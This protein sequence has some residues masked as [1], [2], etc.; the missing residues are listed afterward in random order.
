MGKNFGV[1]CGKMS[2]IFV[3][4]VDVKNK[5]LEAWNLLTEKNQ[6]GCDLIASSPS[7]GK[8]FY[9][10]YESRLANI[11]N[12]AGVVY[13]EDCGL[14]VEGGKVGIDVRSNG[15]YIICPPSANGKYS[16]DV[17][18][19]LNPLP[20]WIFLLLS[21]KRSMKSDRAENENQNPEKR[22]KVTRCLADQFGN[23]RAAMAPV[24]YHQCAKL[25]ER[26]STEKITGYDP[27]EIWGLR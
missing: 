25:C 18:E 3:V 7:G 24:L 15:G 12:A 1:I 23:M 9:Y 4:D 10:L 6:H 19:K 11:K 27:G 14:E 26:I 16:W 8:H 21:K 13:A 20:E 5:G 17:C 22:Q 2:G